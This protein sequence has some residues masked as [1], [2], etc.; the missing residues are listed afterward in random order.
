[1]TTL[2]GYMYYVFCTVYVITALITPFLVEDNFN[3]QTIKYEDWL[4]RMVDHTL[5]SRNDFL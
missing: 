4:H 5:N 1:M 2:Y 3:N